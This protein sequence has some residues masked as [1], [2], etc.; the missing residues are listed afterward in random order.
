MLD[1][2]SLNQAVL[3]AK[4]AS[5]PT[6]VVLDSPHSGSAYPPDFTSVLTHA[7]LQTLEDAYVDELFAPAVSH[8]ATLVSAQFPRGYIDPNRA[9]DDVHPPALADA[10]PHRAQP[11]QKALLG[12]GLVFTRTPNGADIYT[13][14]LT[15]DALLHRI[16]QY[17]KPYHRALARALSDTRA[18]FGFAWH[19]NCHSMPSRSGHLLRSQS[20]RRPDFC[21]G[22]RFGT[23]SDESFMQLVVAELQ[24]LGYETAINEPYAGLECLHRHGNPSKGIHSIQLEINRD[25][26]LDEQSHLRSDGF[27]TLQQRLTRLIQRLG[28]A[29]MEDYRCATE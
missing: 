6:P 19:I 29:A 8:G 20:R 12:V 7:Q 15:S 18:Q 27:A 28:I 1:P 26:Y 10:W 5:Q 2:D 9:I 16:D 11:T 24:A 4:P 23:S 13:K 21:I 25:L 17:Y 3:T 22:D 14:A